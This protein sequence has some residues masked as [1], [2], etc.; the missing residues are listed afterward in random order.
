MQINK[1]II[2][3]KEMQKWRRGEVPYDGENPETHKAMPF[4]PQEFGE[5]IDSLINFTQQTLKT[6]AIT[7]KL[8]GK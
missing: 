4:S 6:T 7:D 3:C 5:A 2:V 8:E 1:A